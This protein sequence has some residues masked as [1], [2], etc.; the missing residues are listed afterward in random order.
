MLVGLVEGIMVIRTVGELLLDLAL[1]LLHAS[2][3]A[4]AGQLSLGA[5]ESCS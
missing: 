3:V 1:S 4:G 2:W 5:P